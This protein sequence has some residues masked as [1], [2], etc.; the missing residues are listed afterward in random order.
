MAKRFALKSLTDGRFSVL[1]KTH[2]Q[3]SAGEI[4]A[5]F[6]DLESAKLAIESAKKMAVE[7]PQENRRQL[8]NAMIRDASK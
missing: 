8:I 5:T 3:D 2:N 1:H 7:L 6:S 4:V